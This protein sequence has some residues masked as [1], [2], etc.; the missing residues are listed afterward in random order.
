MNAY[1]I[2]IDADENEPRSAWVAANAKWQALDLYHE[3]IK[4]SDTWPQIEDVVL[5]TELDQQNVILYDE[6]EG[7]EET[8]LEYMAGVKFPHYISETE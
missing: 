8:L 5:M 7:T 2:I 4:G 1:E 6:D 3:Q